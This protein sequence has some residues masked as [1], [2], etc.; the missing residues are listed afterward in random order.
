MAARLDAEA[1]PIPPRENR[2]RPGTG[3]RCA[4]SSMATTSASEIGEKSS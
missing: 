4:R 3:D 1:L 2:Q